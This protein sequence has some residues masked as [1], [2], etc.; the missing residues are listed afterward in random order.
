MNNKYHKQRLSSIELLRIIAIMFVLLAHAIGVE[1]HLPLSADF[2]S[3]PVDSIFIVLVNSF[4]VGGVDIFVIISGWFGIHASK[5]GLGKYVF[6]VCFLL[7]LILVFF[8]LYD[9]ET[10]TV[11]NVKASFWLYKGYWFIMAYLGMYLLSP[12]LNSFA[13]T[14]SQKQFQTALATLYLFQCYFSWLTNQIVYYEGYSI[15]LLCIL[16]LTARYMRLYPI[17]LINRHALKMYFAI[18]ILIT[19]IVVVSLYIAGHAMRM[20]RYDNP[21]VILSS[22]CIVTAFSKWNFQSRGINRLALSCFAVYIIHFNP[23]VFPYYR[24]GII[25]LYEHTSGISSSIILFVY[26][27]L[28]FII[29]FAIDQLRLLSWNII[30]KFIKDR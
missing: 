11:D 20:L 23:F 21:L 10:L 6:Q 1:Y 16:Y 25:L 24:K 4:I 27:C 30:S 7:W 15:T 12:L 2:T 29:C 19:V 3:Q 9:K 13:A 17:K 22:I 26:L 14:A 8:G 5:K 28:V 18:V